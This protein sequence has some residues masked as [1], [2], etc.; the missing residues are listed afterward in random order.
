MNNDKNQAQGEKKEL[1]LE[2]LGHVVGGAIARGT[3]KAGG[4]GSI[5]GEPVEFP[6]DE[7]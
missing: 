2:E 7:F 4:K 3:V 5:N 6:V 1:T